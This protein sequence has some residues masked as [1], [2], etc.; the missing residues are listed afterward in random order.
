[1]DDDELTM[2]AKLLYEYYLGL[3]SMQSMTSFE[4][5]QNVQHVTTFKYIYIIFNTHI[6]DDVTSST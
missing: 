4:V 3:M 6:N 5:S 2:Q 1:M